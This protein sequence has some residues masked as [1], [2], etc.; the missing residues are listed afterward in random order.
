MG[1]WK[2]SSVIVD[3]DTRR[4]W[5]VSFTSLPLYPQENLSYLSHG[6]LCR[7]ERPSGR[8]GVQKNIL[9]LPEIKRWHSGVQSIIIRS[10]LSRL[11]SEMQVC[12]IVK[13]FFWRWIYIYVK[14]MTRSNGTEAV[15]SI[16]YSSC[17]IEL[18]F[19]ATMKLTSMINRIN[20][21]LRLT[22]FCV[23]K[24]ELYKYFV[25]RYLSSC[26]YLKHN[27]SET[28]VCLRLQAKPTQL[29]PIDRAIPC[30]WGP[31]E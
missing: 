3:L 26:F 4:R 30:R 12:L 15:S 9:T 23:T 17:D 7:P 22:A 10:E 24:F 29:A 31:S 28:G 5:V 25:S 19:S 8:C 6:R 27:V 18:P 2:Y 1:E 13:V 20:C 14:C 21:I 11:L 16:R